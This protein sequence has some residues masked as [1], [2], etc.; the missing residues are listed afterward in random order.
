MLN[1][2]VKSITKW[3]F[4]VS[5]LKYRTKHERIKV[6]NIQ[7]LFFIGIYYECAPLFLRV[8]LIEPFFST[9]LLWLFYHSISF[10]IKRRADRTIATATISIRTRTEHYLSYLKYGMDVLDKNDMKGYCIVMDNAK[11]QY[12]RYQG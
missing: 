3:H 8:F 10:A 7:N 2:T 5:D 12:S 9:D 11:I 1:R 6:W 4:F